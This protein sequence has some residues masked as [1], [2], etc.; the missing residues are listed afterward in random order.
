MALSGKSLITFRLQM[1]HQ[2]ARTRSK[3]FF[4]SALREEIETRTQIVCA[5]VQP[6]R[7]LVSSS[8][9]T[10]W[11]PMQNISHWLHLINTI[12][13]CRR[14]CSFPMASRQI[15]ALNKMKNTWGLRSTQDIHIYKETAPRI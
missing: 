13:A 3:C 2:E 9:Q 12:S 10:G 5:I 1:F 6:T 11:K 8:H 7:F 4:L 14:N 15:E